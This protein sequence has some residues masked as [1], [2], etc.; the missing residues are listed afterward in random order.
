MPFMTHKWRLKKNWNC[1]MACPAEPAPPDAEMGWD[2]EEFIPE[3]SKVSSHLFD[4]FS[5]LRTAH[6][7][8]HEFQRGKAPSW[9]LLSVDHI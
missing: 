4:F 1:G 8:Q 7:R 6:Q 9:Y 5:R 2:F 3:Y